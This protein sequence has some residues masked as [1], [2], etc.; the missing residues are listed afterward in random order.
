M[1]G[2]PSCSH[3]ICFA[4]HGAGWAP[5]LSQTETI[6]DGTDHK[7]TAAVSCK[8]RVEA[9]LPDVLDAPAEPGAAFR[10]F[11]FDRPQIMQYLVTAE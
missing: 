2:N 4:V 10:S 7:L 5:G 9:A 8:R 6:T 11:S 1:P 3:Q